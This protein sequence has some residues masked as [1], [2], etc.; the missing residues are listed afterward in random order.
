MEWTRP[1]EAILE[2][3]VFPRFRFAKL[4]F[5]LRSPE[6][7]TALPGIARNELVSLASSSAAKY[8]AFFLPQHSPSLFVQ[9]FLWKG[10]RNKGDESKGMYWQ[11]IICIVYYT[12][13]T[14]ILLIR[15]RCA[16]LLCNHLLK[17]HYNLRLWKFEVIVMYDTSY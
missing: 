3:C 15:C 14:F 12:K 6:P 8:A 11:Y 2:S 5:T 9:L 7:G 4:V 1:V 10:T 16:C 17:L 13:T